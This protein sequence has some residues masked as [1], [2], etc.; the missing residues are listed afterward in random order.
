MKLA[1][2]ILLSIFVMNTVA[3][4]GETRDTFVI[5]DNN[6]P[7]A[8]VQIEA[9]KRVAF[10]VAEK[11]AQNGLPSWRT[12]K[13]EG[14]TLTVLDPRAPEKKIMDF[15]TQEIARKNGISRISVTGLVNGLS[16]DGKVKW[17]V[18]SF[19]VLVDVAPDG[20]I[21]NGPELRPFDN[22]LN[23]DQDRYFPLNP[24]PGPYRRPE[25]RR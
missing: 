2:L 4:A 15:K 11:H 7:L 16:P 19:R 20:R 17:G 3:N 25:G 21:V 10:P 24:E 22:L 13:Y 5:G 8:A 6:P 1:A 12:H 9:A 14:W 23:S 18:G